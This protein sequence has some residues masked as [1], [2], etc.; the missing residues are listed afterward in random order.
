LTSNGDG[1]CDLTGQV[2]THFAVT[3]PGLVLTLPCEFNVE[4]EG[5]DYFSRVVLR[6]D[7]EYC[8][9][10]PS[11]WQHCRRAPLILHY[12]A[13]HKSQERLRADIQGIMTKGGRENLGRLSYP[14]C[15]QST[16]RCQ[17]KLCCTDQ[18][19]CDVN[20]DDF[21]RTTQ[22]EVAFLYKGADRWFLDRDGDPRK[23]VQ[24]T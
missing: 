3:N 11:A 20:A 14:V 17:Q 10:V 24:T 16:S 13:G 2:Y 12:N 18:M 19:L 4:S 15:G 21:A 9:S 6:E 7:F 1:G 23:E 8:A 22:E 5:H